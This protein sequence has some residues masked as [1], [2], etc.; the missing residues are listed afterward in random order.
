MRDDR[1]ATFG[2]AIGSHAGDRLCESKARRCV[3]RLRGPG[4]KAL[5]LRR[6][7]KGG[8]TENFRLRGKIYRGGYHDR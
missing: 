7:I 2:T 3:P 8:L 1:T 4:T 5:L 6:A